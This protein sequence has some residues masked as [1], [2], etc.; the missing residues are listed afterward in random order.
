MAAQTIFDKLLIQ[1]IREGKVP[2]RT[3]DAREWYRNSV[4]EY[5]GKSGGKVNENFLKNDKDRIRTTIKPGEMYM[6]H[7]DAKHKDT[8]PYWDRFPLVFPFRVESNRFW[9]LNLHYLPLK[10]RA[11]LMD[12][13]YT[14]AGNSR[15]D[16]TTKL[17]LSYEV[18]TSASKF[19]MFKP[20][21]K[22]YLT[23]Q[24]TSK[25]LYIYPS[26]WDMA[27]FLPVE[28]FVGAT[29]SQVWRDSKEQLR[30]N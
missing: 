9:G 8:L 19:R 13:L 16:E 28:R 23:S 21:V 12:A 6:Y 17:K 3:Q 7:Y 14:L 4:G 25:F 10:E 27:L 18:L 29:K 24:L 30:A 22:Q 11:M 2:A 15:Y 1:G 5:V 20:C 26:E